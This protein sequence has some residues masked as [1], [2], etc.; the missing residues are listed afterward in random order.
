MN[1]SV[2]QLTDFG[3]LAKKYLPRIPAESF[4]PVVSVEQHDS[5][6]PSDTNTNPLLSKDSFANNLEQSDISTKDMETSAPANS[7]VNLNIDAETISALG[8]VLATTAKTL[9][10]L[11][12][13]PVVDA[14]NTTAST[15]VDLVTKPT[16]ITDA[17]GNQHKGASLWE[18]FTGGITNALGLNDPNSFSSK[19][20]NA[21]S[22]FFSP[23]TNIFQSVIDLFTIHDSRE[24]RAEARQ[25]EQE[26]RETQRREEEDLQRY[27]ALQDRK[28]E[29]DKRFYE[30]QDEKRRIAEQAEEA[31][32][33]ENERRDSA[34]EEEQRKQKQEE[35]RKQEIRGIVGTNVPVTNLDTIET[36]VNR[37]IE[38]AQ[39]DDLDLF[40]EL[41]RVYKGVD[42]SSNIGRLTSAGCGEHIHKLLEKVR[43][44][45]SSVV[46]DNVTKEIIK[47]HAANPQQLNLLT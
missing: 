13:A 2:D 39:G 31:E 32:R 20:W 11:P 16:T 19:L 45:P 37:A 38:Q 26:I 15:A 18:Q 10:P 42:L 8:S 28:R 9:L 6:N 34:H 24:E 44:A 3:S 27:Y 33:S 21:T 23:I 14:V 41:M 40:L 47:Q 5:K 1:S 36:V 30:A 17:D 29:D 43:S 22:E 4:N 35:S 12:M 25:R 46:A 7:I